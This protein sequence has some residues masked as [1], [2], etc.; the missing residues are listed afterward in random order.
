MRGP[1]D[2]MEDRESGGIGGVWLTGNAHYFVQL[3]PE[4]SAAAAVPL[5]GCGIAGDVHQK[6]GGRAASAGDGATAAVGTGQS[7]QTIREPGSCG[8]HT[9]TTIYPSNP[10]SG[11]NGFAFGSCGRCPLYEVY[12][13]LA[14][15]SASRWCA[16]RQPANTCSLNGNSSV[17]SRTC[18]DI[19]AIS[20]A[21]CITRR[22]PTWHP[23]Q[24]HDVWSLKGLRFRHVSTK[25]HYHFQATEGCHVCG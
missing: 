12:N 9:G 19:I 13:K 8:S 11:R 14:L 4:P 17:L 5:Q 22:Y 20:T 10:T 2:T 6:G 3:A 16:P 23:N 7:C 1:V 21:R 24:G 15:V 25:E 18:I